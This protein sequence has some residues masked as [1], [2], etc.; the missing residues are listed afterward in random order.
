MRRLLR[1]SGAVAL[2]AAVTASIGWLSQAPYDAASG[3]Q[4]LLRLSWRIRGAK[5]EECRELSAE[6][7]QQLP[8]HMQLDEICEGRVA[9]YHLS[10]VVDD[11]RLI[12][13]TVRAEGARQDRPIYV[14]QELRLPPGR[15]T[16]QVTFR[17]LISGKVENSTRQ[18]TAPS[19]LEL[20][21][22]IA[23][24]PGTIALVTYDDERERLVVR[25]TA[26]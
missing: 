12:S 23:L 19:V 10:L 26:R 24:A 2:A 6:E 15:H 4:A 14:F 25:G 8:P 5:V 7:R 18:R 3:E 1:R 16:L 20:V 22:N 13:D 11:R 21:S 17:R 9:P